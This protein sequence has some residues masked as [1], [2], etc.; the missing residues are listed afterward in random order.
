MVE[1]FFYFIGINI[2][3][4]RCGIIRRIDSFELVRKGM[5]LDKGLKFCRLI[6]QT[7]RRSW[8]LLDF[9]L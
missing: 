3:I 7:F 6:D 9:L 8:V 5:R 2:R 1:C 4:V